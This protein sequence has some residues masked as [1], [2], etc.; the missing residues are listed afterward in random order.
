MSEFEEILK[1]SELSKEGVEI[2]KTLFPNYIETYGDWIRVEFINI[3]I[4][5]MGFDWKK[6]LKELGID[7]VK[8]AF[9][10]R[11]YTLTRIVQTFD[12]NYNGEKKKHK[13]IMWK[14]NKPIY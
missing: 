9:V 2:I 3:P 10:Q 12:Y 8:Q 14:V 6:Q 1:L 5:M 7:A 11:G 4:N 13:L